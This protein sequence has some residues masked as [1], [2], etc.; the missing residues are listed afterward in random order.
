MMD[1]D[2][3]TIVYRDWCGELCGKHCKAE[4][5]EALGDC[6]DCNACVNVCSMGI[7]IRDGQQLVCIIC[8]L[9]IDVCNDVMDK[10]G[11]LRDLIG[12]F[13]LLDE[14]LECVGKSVILV[15]KHVFRLRIIF[16]IVFWA[17]VGIVLVVFLFLRVDMDMSVSLICNLIYVVLL[18]G[19]VCNAYE[20][21]L[22]N[23]IGE[24]CV[25]T[26]LITG[27]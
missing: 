23:M 8:G 2:T 27:L 10:V 16:Y 18:D 11:K 5:A 20:V 6:I 24:A 17:G 22:R 13:A 12:Y 4:G 14:V 19:S 3:I 25:F 21:C 9:C 7:D 15:W 26:I 1:E